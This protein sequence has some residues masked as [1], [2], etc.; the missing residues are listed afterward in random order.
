MNLLQQWKINKMQDSL[1]IL[2]KEGISLTLENIPCII[3][4]MSFRV[5]SKKH[6]EECPYYV[7]IADADECNF[8]HPKVQT[9][10]PGL[11]DFKETS[12]HPEVENLNCFL[13][14]C[15]NYESDKLAGG[16]KINSQKGRVH[17]HPNLPEGR[18]WDCSDC[19]INHTPDEIR[20]YLTKYISELSNCLATR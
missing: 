8:E 3:E 6:P 18:I 2:K 16:C 1:S 7:K 15:P 4:E 11:L 13:C 5:R 19:N 17:F 9:N 14:A 10:T 20:R 12:C